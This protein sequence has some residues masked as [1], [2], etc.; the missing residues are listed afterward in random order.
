MSCIQNALLV[1]RCS[2]HAAGHALLDTRC[3][4][5]AAR[6]MLLVT[7]CSAAD[8]WLKSAWQHSQTPV[9]PNPPRSSAS[10]LATSSHVM[11]GAGTRSA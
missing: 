6:R 11:R 1:T 2:S 5:R 8:R 10:R 3:S 9:L 7:R 4:S